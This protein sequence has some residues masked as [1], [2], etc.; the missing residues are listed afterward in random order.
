MEHQADA[1]AA[2]K[3]SI[4]WGSERRQATAR[5]CYGSNAFGQAGKAFRYQ[6]LSFD[7]FV[8]TGIE[9]VRFSTPFQAEYEGSIPFTR[10][11]NDFN[12]FRPR[13]FPIRTTAGALRPSF[14]C[15]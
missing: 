6:E 5:R 2:G 14:S 1:G 3:L 7:H 8:R 15:L 4:R 11:K 13:Q 12:D 9:V 10:S